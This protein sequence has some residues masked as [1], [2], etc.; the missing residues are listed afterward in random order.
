MIFNKGAPDDWDEWER[1]GNSG[2][3]FKDIEPLMQKAEHFTPSTKS[4]LSAEEM[5]QHG[6]NGPWQIGYS[7]QSTPAAELFVDACAATGFE[8]VRDLN[9]RR[10]T[11]SCPT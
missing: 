7:H 11:S 2:W 6:R 4:P 9:S 8:K 5:D 3:G 10:G 1:L